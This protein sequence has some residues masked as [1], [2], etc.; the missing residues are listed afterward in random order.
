MH[1]LSLSKHGTRLFLCD[2]RLWEQM[3]LERFSQYATR[4]H[5]SAK[6]G[7]KQNLAL[8]GVFH[9]VPQPLS[10]GWNCHHE[11]WPP[12]LVAMTTAPFTS[13]LDTDQD[14]FPVRR[15]YPYS[16]SKLN[17]VNQIAMKADLRDL[18]RQ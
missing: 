5:P 14:E 4:G 11:P 6:H 8:P 12:A 7:W 16:K 2:T 9:T 10:P 13:R 1:A 17:T 18:R 15:L 3:R